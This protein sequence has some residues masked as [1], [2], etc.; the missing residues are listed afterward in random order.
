MPRTGQEGSPDEVEAVIKDLRE[1]ASRKGLTRAKLHKATTI[2]EIIDR[3]NPGADLASQVE[4]ADALI[5]RQVD[6]VRNT[7]DHRLLT[8]GLNLDGR[9]GSSIENRLLDAIRELEIAD[10]KVLVP[11]SLMGRFRYE[12][13]RELAWRIL[14]GGP[15]TPVPTPPRD[16]F[17]VA[18]RLVAQ[19]RHPE[20][21][22][23]LRTVASSTEDN[24]VRQDAWR[25]I[26]TMAV[27]RSQYDEAESAFLEALAVPTESLKGGKLTMAID[28]YASR[29]TREEDYDRAAAIVSTALAKFFWSGWLWRR[30]GCVKWYAGDLITAYA[31]L[32][33][34]LDRGYARSRV[35][36]ARGQV[37]AELGR[38]SEAIE[39]LTE[40]FTFSRSVLSNAYIHSAR[41]FAIGMTGDLEVALHEFSEAETVIPDSGWLYFWRALCLKQHGLDDESRTE[42]ERALKANAAPLNRPKR[43]KA[44]EL[45]EVWSPG[46]V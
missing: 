45:L 9:S 21:T 19:G 1:L 16:E 6:N 5:R 44:I 17:A 31:A 40:A 22:Q 30:Y 15:S 43:E 13:L 27:E 39:E 2:L 25:T 38:Y 18:V 28:R 4:S 14:T 33:T 36:H 29:L 32:S 7:L 20:A 10:H 34:A 8:A 26:A 37:L 35:L 42:L 23:L 11:E 41:A 12:L 24:Q 3:R 46:Y